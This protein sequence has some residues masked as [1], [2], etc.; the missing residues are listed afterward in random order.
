MIPALFALCGFA[1]L[2]LAGLL[3]GVLLRS[4]RVEHVACAHCGEPVPFA[5]NQRI[6]CPECGR[7]A[8]PGPG[9]SRRP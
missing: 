9:R 8:W 3:T 2:L 6:V 5:G 1:L 7:V 4:G